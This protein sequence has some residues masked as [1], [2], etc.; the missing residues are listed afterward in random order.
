MTLH[1]NPIGKRKRKV[2]QLSAS[3]LGLINAIM[4]AGAAH[5]QTTNAPAPAATSTNAPAKL[6]DVIVTGEQGNSY[7]PENLSS[8]KYTVP[9]V[10]VPQSVT[11]IPQAVFEEQNATTLRDVLRNVPGISIQAGEGGV[12]AGDNLS[13]RGFN[14]RTDLFVDGMRDLG[15]YS[16]DPFNIS[17]VEV[18]KGPSSSFGGRGSTGGSVNLVSKSPELDSFYGGTFGLGTD[19]YKRATLDVNQPLKEIG[20][21]NGALRLNGMWHDAEVPG[22]D[23]VENERWGVAP[24]VAFGLGT[25]T[26]VTFSYFHL[27]QDNLPDYGIPWVPAGNTNAVLAAHTDEAPPVD[28]SNF[29][30]L[31]RR[32]YEKTRTDIATLKAEH[33][34][35]DSVTLRT[36]LRFGQNDRD[37]IITAPRFLDF[38]PS[39]TNA[40][41]GTVIN[42]QIQSRDQVDRILANQTDLT[43]KFDTAK[44]EHTVVTG[45]ELAEETSVNYARSGPSSFTD[46]FNPNPHDPY[47]GQINRTGAKT[48]AT[49]TSGALYVFDTI[50]LHEKWEL[51]G[52]LRGDYFDLDYKSRATNGVTT[53]L[54]R[55]DEALSWRIGA[56]YKPLPN[57]SIY[58]GYGT[59]F[60]PSAEGLTLANTA[61]AA[62]N[63]NN[64]PE[65]SRSFEIGTKWEF[66][67]RR[68]LLTAAIFRTEKINARTEDPIDT[69][70]VVVLDG[71]QRIDGFEFGFAG[72]LTKEWEV[73]GGYSFYDSEVTKS[74]NAVE[75]GRQLA[76]TPEHS[77]SLWT[78]YELPWDFEVGVGAQFVDS[79][80][81]VTANPR[82]EAPSYYL[83]DAMAAYN[84]TKDISLR[85]NVY[86]LA[87]EEYIDR[88]GGGHFIPGAGRSATLTASFKF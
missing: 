6:P 56:V 44:L 51:S 8:P 61:T 47:P 13:I 5:S 64:D 15:G 58:A 52:G 22:R 50:K 26:R 86:N 36:Q 74:K 39:P 71:N 85:L 62:N 31:T 1:Q 28:F 16:R 27:D 30:G 34:F 77:F 35:N 59:S 10:D 53:K 21:E 43:L 46:I 57:G 88:V 66:F 20:L 12:P 42:R 81:N 37:S 4:L 78:T 25:P 9:L 60:N 72:S 68:L 79:R 3:T 54:D 75:E 40:V 41:F 17:Q 45:L 67:E 2:N 33:D 14:A 55:T 29:Y 19:E 70:D 11:V 32:D 7:K 83:F 63:V 18:V 80:F 73:S 49:A 24:S 76:Q 38:D 87:D 48:D 23:E 65:K 69:T 84:V 82:R